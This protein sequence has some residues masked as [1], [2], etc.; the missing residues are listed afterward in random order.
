MLVIEDCAWSGIDEV[1]RSGN[2]S[3]SIF[4]WDMLVLCTNLVTP[5]W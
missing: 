5:P 3:V 2:E 1:G 4:Q